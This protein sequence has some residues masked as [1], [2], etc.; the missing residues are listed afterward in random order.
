[1]DLSGY[2]A[3]G[4]LFLVAVYTLQICARD[5]REA[6]KSRSRRA[7]LY[8]NL[9]GTGSRGHRDRLAGRTL[10]DPRAFPLE[11][12]TQPGLDPMDST[13]Q[14]G[15]AIRS[16]ISRERSR[17]EDLLIGQLAGVNA[18]DLDPH[19]V[20]GVLLLLH[21]NCARHTDT[22]RPGGVDR[23][24]CSS[25]T[26]SARDGGN[27]HNLAGA[28]EAIRKGP[29][30]SQR[31]QDSVQNARERRAVLLDP[32]PAVDLGRD[33]AIPPLEDRHAANPRRHKWTVTLPSSYRR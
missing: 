1:M 21:E 16:S 8:F 33:P 6:R 13:T 28:S 30:E 5:F 32:R 11:A 9:R 31:E 2:A 23:G 25:C 4:L 27:G 19:F 15:C 10:L 22:A 24:R 17:I 20:T 14:R 12:I 26:A 18:A 29:L 7:Y 3:V